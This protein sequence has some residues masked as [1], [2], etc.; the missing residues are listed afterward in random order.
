MNRWVLDRWLIG[1]LVRAMLLVAVALGGLL[2]FFDLLDALDRLGQPGWSVGRV[3]A[4]AALLQPG[5]WL[6]M[7]PVALLVGTLVALA[8][9]TRYQELTILRASGLSPVGLWRRIAFS[10]LIAA[11]ATTVLGEAVVPHTEQTARQWEGG[12]P[13]GLWVRE[14]NAYLHLGSVSPAGL[15]AVWWYRLDAE[16]KRLAAIDFAPTGHYD[17]TLPGW[18]FP[19]VVR[20]TFLPEQIVEEQLTDQV[21]ASDLT[22]ETLALLWI[23][24]QRMQLAVLA[25]YVAFLQKNGQDAYIYEVALWRKRLLPLTMVVMATLAIP[26]VLTQNRTAA[27]GWRLLAGTFL[28]VFFYLVDLLSARLVSLWYL[29]PP[30]A[31]ALPAL[32]FASLAAAL[33]WRAERR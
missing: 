3:L 27:M 28:G 20:R 16:G 33:W 5:R 24:P 6:E 26:F 12:R 7:A 1:G 4:Y 8:Q 17:P 23:E 15:E 10:A 30:L 19:E 32:T 11:A 21:W 13:R 9:W 29:P 25:R 22:P 2:L 18:R 14:G 31:A